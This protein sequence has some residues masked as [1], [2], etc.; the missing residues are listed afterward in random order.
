MISKTNK[1]KIRKF[2]K[3]TYTPRE[4][5]VWFYVTKTLDCNLH[6]SEG[7]RSACLYPVNKEGTTDWTKPKRINL[8]N[9]K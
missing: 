3:G 6:I 1:T 4:D 2:L 5:D 7:E 9:L 8:N